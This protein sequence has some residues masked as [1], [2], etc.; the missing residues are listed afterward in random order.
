MTNLT[1]MKK[2]F[3]TVFLALLSCITYAQ[4]IPLSH[5]QPDLLQAFAGTDTLICKNHTIILG[6]SQTA[7]GGTPDYF[8]T[9]YPETYLD[10]PTSPNPTCSP[11]ESTTYILTVTDNSGCTSTSIVSVGV[12]QCLGIPLN[13]N[14]IDISVYPNP[15]SD[16]FI[17]QGLPLE[18]QSI[19]IRLVNQ[20]GQTILKRLAHSQSNSSDIRVESH[21]IIQPGFY[22]IQVTID[23]QVITKSIQIL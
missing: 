9:W 14:S 5:S 13:Y 15:A 3:T 12:D 19:D 10:N 2:S 17:I 18:A 4:V 20:L 23:D 11:E 8:Y 22:L 1:I 16:Y 21:E 6:S 7:I